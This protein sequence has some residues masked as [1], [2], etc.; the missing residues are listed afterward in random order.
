MNRVARLLAENEQLSRLADNLLAMVQ[1]PIESPEA[2]H[3]AVEE[4]ARVLD[5]HLA[6]E[7]GFPYVTILHDELDWSQAVK[8]RRD[9]DLRELSYTWEPYFG[10]W[11]AARI[12]ADPVGFAEATMWNMSHLLR[13]VAVEDS[14]LR[15]CATP[16]DGRRAGVGCKLIAVCSQCGDTPPGDRR[17]A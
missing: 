7:R 2:A 4:I 9:R 12:E 11:S 17:A 15:A 5:R 1:R 16:D 6:F 8:Q 14:I 10:H 13:R 3:A